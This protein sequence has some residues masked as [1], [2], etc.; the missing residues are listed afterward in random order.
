MAG[1]DL[2]T[3][4]LE[5]KLDAIM[6]QLTSMSKVIV[7][8]DLFD[9]WRDGNNDRLT[10]LEGDVRR[11]IET[12]TGAHVELDKDSKAR[13]TESESHIRELRTEM[14]S[15]FQQ[16]EDKAFK[17]EQ[18]QKAQRSGR[19][20]SVGLAVLVSILGVISTLFITLT[21]LK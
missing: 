16:N 13:H 6:E 2:T 15:R 10:R 4:E 5:V 11:W 20:F 21:G 1:R 3:G 17:I 9:T 7:T 14:E 19:W 18:D 12:S 8:R